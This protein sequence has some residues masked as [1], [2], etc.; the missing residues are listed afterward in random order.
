MAK[1]WIASISKEHT[2]R[3]VQGNFIQVCHGKEAPLKRM[4]KGDFIIIYSS[5]IA[6]TDKE[7]YQKF[8]AIG[9]LLDD[10]IYQYAMSETFCPFRRKVRF[11]ACDETSILP[12]INE[13]DFI[14]N[15]QRWGYPFRYGYFEISEKD[16]QLIA[17]KMLLQ[18][19]P[20]VY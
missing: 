11:F 5:K 19:D 4:S 18:A 12:L 13:L 7:K 1:F 9:E 10:E 2:L 20:G 6:M 15:K 16:Y 8:T 3:G 14:Q 17:A